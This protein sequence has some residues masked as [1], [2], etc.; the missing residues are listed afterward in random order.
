YLYNP[1]DPVPNLG[2]QNQPFDLCGPM[3]QRDIEN[4]G[5][6]LIFQTANLTEPVETVGRIW[7]YHPPT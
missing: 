5:D 1:I 6:V 2:G 3:D 7:S 4:R